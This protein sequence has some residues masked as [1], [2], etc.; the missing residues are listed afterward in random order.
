MFKLINCFPYRKQITLARHRK[1]HTGSQLLVKKFWDKI[2]LNYSTND[3]I[4]LQINGKTIR[5][6]IGNKLT[7]NKRKEP[8][9][10]LIKKEWENV[11]ANEIN[12]FLLP[13]TSLTT[14]CIDLE[15]AN[16]SKDENLKIKT[17]ADTQIIFNDLL[18]YLDTDTLLVFAPQN[19]LDGKLRLE[20]DKLY[21]P[22]IK[23]AEK[24]F[25]GKYLKYN[26]A[27]VNASENNKTKKENFTHLSILDADLHGIRGNSQ[28]DK[29]RQ[30][31]LNYLNT[32]TMWELAIFEKTVIVTKSF[33]CGIL[34]IENKSRKTTIPDLIVD[35]DDIIRAST[36]ETI[37]Q[38]ERWGEVEDTHDINRC[39]MYRN[40]L[41]ASIVA[42]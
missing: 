39:E 19:E 28:P 22:I 36:L 40:I 8:L 16:K 35:V 17:G 41:T 14:R 26:D 20:Q 42:Y 34:L 7:L 15:M 38:I 6:P 12:P 30:A 9:A 18:K 2:N 13:L 37:Y 11:C 33:I 1:L 5:T 21:L 32:L 4:D 10:Y 24:L 25:N 27:N 23:G 31:A 29:I 3:E